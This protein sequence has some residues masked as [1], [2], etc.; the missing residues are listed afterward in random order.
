[1]ITALRGRWEAL[2]ER[3]LAVSIL[4]REN[5]RTSRQWQTYAYR[6]LFS[7]ALLSMVLVI[8]WLVV[9]SEYVDKS[10]L[11]WLGRGLFI[12]FT[13]V[14][15]LM[16]FG[17]APAVAASAVT[18]ELEDR[19]AEILA[20]TRLRPTEILVGK[21]ASRVLVLTLVSLGALPVTAIIA[22]LGGVSVF[23]VLAT[24]M[25]H[26]I[27]IAVL[28]SFGALFALFTRSILLAVLASGAATGLLYLGPA[29]I[30]VAMV[31]DPLDSAH[32]SPL[33]GSS[34]VDALAFLPVLA[35]VPVVATILGVAGPVFDLSVAGATATRKLTGPAWQT[36]RAGRAALLLV[37]TSIP[38]PLPV[39]ACW[40]LQLGGPILHPYVDRPLHFAMQGLV[41][42][43]WVLAL[44]VGAW[45]LARVGADLVDAV[46]KLSSRRRTQKER[47]L[48]P[49]IWG[50][51]VAW[52][53]VRPDRW[54][55]T[56]GQTL[57][58]V[59]LASLAFVQSGIVLVPGGLVLAGVC[60]TIA[61]FLLATWWMTRAMERERSD[62][63][64]EV[65]LTSPIS[66][67]SV[68]RG[69]LA[70][71]LVPALPLLV[72]TGPVY[73]L[74]T[75]YADAVFQDD[76][77]WIHLLH[78][79]AV[80]VWTLPVWLF[81]V[82]MALVVTLRTRR[83][84]TA[85]STTL[86]VAGAVLVVAGLAGRLFGDNPWIAVP[87]RILSPPLAGADHAM[88]YVL[89]TLLVSV[90]AVGTL[91]WSGFRLR[92]WIGMLAVLLVATV[93]VAAPPPVQDGFVLVAEPL[94]DGIA[95]GDAWIG[96]RVEIEN[97]G[98]ADQGTLYLAQDEGPESI[99][100]Q[101]PIEL[102]E[103]ARKS[104]VLLARPAGYGAP[105]VVLETPGGRRA[106]VPVAWRRVD[107]DAVTIGVLGDDPV[108]L[109]GVATTRA[110][111]V[112]GTRPRALADAPRAVRTGLI[113][114]SGVPTHSAALFGYDWLVWTRADPT[115]LDP[116]QVAALGHFVA[117]G[118]N[119]LLTVTDTAAA[120]RASPVAEWLPVELGELRDLPDA[121]ALLTALGAP[122]VGPVAVA[123]PHAAL[124]GDRIS[125]V[126]ASAADGEPL[127]V[128]GRYGLGTVHVLLADLRTAPLAGAPR[129]ATWRALLSIEK[130]P[131]DL[132]PGLG[133]ALRIDPPMYDCAWGGHEWQSPIELWTGTLRERLNDIPGVAP[134]PL[135]W[136]L[137]FALVYLLLI[138]P[139]DWFVLRALG[140]Q[141]LT[142]VTFP[143]TIV[144]FSG[145][146]LVG[147]SITKGSQ[148]V[149]RQVQ[150]VDQLPGTGLWRGTTFVGLFA[151]RKT[152]VKLTSG[153]DDGVVVPLEQSGFLADPRVEV[154]EG[155]GSELYGAETWSLSYHRTAWV[156][157]SPGTVTLRRARGGYQVRNG[158]TVPLR[159]ARLVQGARLLRDIGDL[160]PGETR[161]VD[162]SDAPATDATVPPGTPT[163]DVVAAWTLAGE[164][165]DL[166]LPH[167]DG[168]GSNATL[169][170]LL[171]APVER[172]GVEGVDPLVEGFTVL[173][174]PLVERTSDVP[175]LTT[176]LEPISGPLSVGGFG[177][178]PELD[179]CILG[180]PPAESL[181]LTLP[182]TVGTDGQVRL[183]TPGD[184]PA[185]LCVHGRLDGYWGASAAEESRMQ[186]VLDW[187]V[188]PPPQEPQ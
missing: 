85:Y 8:L 91:L 181:V 111:G 112:P 187:N 41:W 64:L 175:R 9:G 28:S 49:Q 183:D 94:G 108:G 78:G 143:I 47:R 127:W 1:M 43:W 145:I 73:M 161:T 53:A 22:T 134:L 25:H 10:S 128:S 173:R 51:P 45:G 155:P 29:P 37:F 162:L 26:L 125:W 58:A 102:P 33:L 48:Q 19:T 18:E 184:H 30:Y 182:F 130:L 32:L 163:E 109:N 149:M 106:V 178:L 129:D 61:A 90:A 120:V 60:G 63:T 101:R 88:E 131:P 188:P 156:A 82:A 68:I 140:R 133:A 179:D 74:G 132:P 42:A 35:F 66:T 4:Q 31:A 115:R 71:A 176:R 75:L 95:R 107:D 135:P 103:G 110:E 169:L 92:R 59:F 123:V 164:A 151:T 114:L 83:L 65:L 117:A 146:A 20:L 93:A 21:V 5:A 113:P 38:L 160:Q 39:I 7:G 105:V 16:I 144:V 79:A 80:W 77:R 69:H 158:L 46:E 154:G 52:Y 139:V 36:A 170:A 56:T 34:A 126:R 118:G 84:R 116:A 121:D 55:T 124:R 62:G 100:Y 137:G 14:Q 141:P 27:S 136:V 87:A 15:Q 147:T 97:L 23:E 168:P 166:G 13:V 99:G 157:D 148:S 119:L 142:W 76:F 89:G 50:N 17:L 159:S 186:V 86:G 2:R 40:F 180:D 98:A 6:T 185:A 174:V 96:F 70:G 57:F 167:Y 150:L 122:P 177:A 81:G 24:S 153:F 165:L 11:G 44:V 12:G 3:T 104:V 171:D 54:L 172:I 67:G 72:L 152:T 138:G